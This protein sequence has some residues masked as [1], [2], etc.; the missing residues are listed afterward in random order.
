[1]T[2]ATKPKRARLIVD[3]SPE[4]PREWDNVGHV[5]GWHRRYTLGDEQ[6]SME[7]NDWLQYLAGEQVNAEDPELIPVEHVSRIIDKYFVLLPIYMYDHSGVALRTAPFYDPWDSGQVGY[8][9]CT[10]VKAMEESGAHSLEQATAWALERLASEVAT[11]SQYINGEVFGYVLEEGEECDHGETQWEHVD[12]C[13]G[14]FGSDPREN[15]MNEHI[16]KEW[17]ALLAEAE[18]EAY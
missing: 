5:V 18:I 16:D 3:Q 17:Q 10:K 12:S 8:I 2:T 14:F 15:G 11:Y 13:W 6:P 1:M 7:P 4:S 9:Y